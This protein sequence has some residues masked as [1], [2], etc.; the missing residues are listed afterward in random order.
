LFKL[1]DPSNM[2]LFGAIIGIVGGLI[3]GVGAYRA[4]RNQSLEQTELR[5]K[6]DEV[7]D[8]QRE[9]RKKSDEIAI[10]QSKLREKSDEMISLQNETITSVMGSGIPALLVDMPFDGLPRN[11]YS[12]IMLNHGKHNL[13]D[14]RIRITEAIYPTD[15]EKTISEK[16]NNIKGYYVGILAPT[17][18]THGVFRADPRL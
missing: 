3:S 5:K 13:Y 7:A 18:P 15:S 4:A 9:L 17:L 16:I 14:V 8:S 11:A 10:L 2:V 6:A 12:L 1:I